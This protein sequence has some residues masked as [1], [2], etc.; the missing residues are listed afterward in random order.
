MK[1][2]LFILGAAA[3]VLASCAK[4]ETVVKEVADNQIAFKAVTNVMTK[5]NPQLEDVTNLPT[6]GYTMIVSAT[7]RNANGQVENAAFFND[8]AFAYEA[9]P[10]KAWVS[11]SPYYWPVGGGTMDFLAY[12]VATTNASKVGTVTWPETNK[13]DKV[14]FTGV[15]V[16]ADGVD[17]MYAAANAQK[18][19]KNANEGTA[20][21]VTLN[22]NHAG[23]VID[24]D[25]TPNQAMTINHLYF[26][27]LT[28]DAIELASREYTSLAE[29][30][31]F[32]VDNSRNVLETKWEYTQPTG[33]DYD[34]CFE[35]TTFGA[36]TKDT[37][38]SVDDIM[39]VPQPKL[40]FIIDYT[41]GSNNMVITTN[42]LKGNW[43]AGHK[44]T[45]QINLNLYEIQILETVVDYID[46]TTETVTIDPVL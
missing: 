36:L 5:A 25:I 9:D 18:G 11:A 33:V 34:S 27:N 19:V 10:A 23:A 30:G 13:A 43:L 42:Q 16:T 39:I 3:L 1:K 38:K 7:S 20:K 32:T 14:V 28:K 6:T 44:Y 45:Y 46:E 2:V 8:V 17:L 15:D 41:V 35:F 24:I 29:S 26:G 4:S 37:K 40:N 12:A 31:T 22:F 21:T